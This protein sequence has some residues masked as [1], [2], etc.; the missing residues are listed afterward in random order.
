MRVAWLLVAAVLGVGSGVAGTLLHQQW[1]GLAL[2]LVTGL[3]VLTWLPP[4]GVRLAFALGW[5]LAVVRGAL[6]GPG[7]GY[8]IGSNVSG[9]SWL[10][11]SFA[12]LLAALATIRAPRRNA[13]DPVDRGR[14]T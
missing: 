7:G 5:C 13:E 11:W 8:L 9:W 2:A 12:L 3:V 1:W 6:A 4:G 14:P 10:V